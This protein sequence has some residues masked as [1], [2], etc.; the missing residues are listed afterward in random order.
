MW[1]SDNLPRYRA[2]AT[3]IVAVLLFAALTAC[4]FQPLYGEQSASLSS[5]PNLS[6]VSVSQVNSRVA[7]QVRNHLIFLLHGNSS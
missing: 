3:R 7:Q 1:L 2:N 6:A 5:G 4:Q